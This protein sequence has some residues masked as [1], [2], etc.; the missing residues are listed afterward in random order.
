M[1]STRRAGVGARAVAPSRPMYSHVTM[2][3]VADVT[4]GAHELAVV[5]L[6]ASGQRGVDPAL[7]PSEDPVWDREPRQGSSPR[8][9]ESRPMDDLFH[10][11]PLSCPAREEP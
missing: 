4:T 7:Q 10:G 8:R 2:V 5:L 9:D 1:S 11:C 6:L 3:V